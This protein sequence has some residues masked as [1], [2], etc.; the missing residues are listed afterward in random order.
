MG[1]GGS[2]Q[3]GTV[4]PLPSPPP[5]RAACLPE[6][7]PHAESLDAEPF[8]CGSEPALIPPSPTLLTPP[9]ALL[10]EPPQCNGDSQDPPVPPHEPGRDSSCARA[11]WD[12][13][14]LAGDPVCPDTGAVLSRAP[15]PNPAYLETEDSPDLRA[16]VLAPP[17]PPPSPPP[18]SSSSR[19]PLPPSAYFC[20]CG[21]RFPLPP[22]LRPRWAIW[23]CNPCKGQ[24]DC[25]SPECHRDYLRGDTWP[26][27]WAGTERPPYHTRFF[28]NRCQCG[29]DLEFDPA[30][31]PGLP[32]WCCKY[33]HG[34]DKRHSAECDRERRG[35]R[36]RV[37][38]PASPRPACRDSHTP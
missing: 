34:T 16:L 25:H 23:C 28:G 18:H 10:L 38:L 27:I 3:R 17:P 29:R 1:P 33:C 12:F 13:R 5:P 4:L 21:R 26:E 20:P 22:H 19:T 7:T 15:W 31:R 24:G 9:C 2:V 8:G 30:M 35:R 11:R 36:P 6:R 14:V 37:P 32:T